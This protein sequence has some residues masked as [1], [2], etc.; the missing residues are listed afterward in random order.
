MKKKQECEERS[1]IIAVETTD[2]EVQTS[3]SCSN[4]PR[5]SRASRNFE[6]SAVQTDQQTSPNREAEPSVERQLVRNA[7]VGK[8]VV[9]L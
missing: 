6:S 3:G 9:R 5:L 4:S 2:R 7:C 1:K 8:V